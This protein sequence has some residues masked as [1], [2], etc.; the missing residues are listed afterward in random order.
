MEV[1]DEV[2]VDRIASRGVVFHVGERVYG[3]KTL[4]C[5]GAVLGREGPVTVENAWIGP[6]ADLRRGVLPGIDLPG[7][8]LFGRRGPGPGGLPSRGKKAG[9]GI[10]W[11]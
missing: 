3:E 1:G 2:S 8:R 5:A 11:A 9:E 6:A 10:R 4:V 7:S